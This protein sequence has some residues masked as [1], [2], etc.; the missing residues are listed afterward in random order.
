MICPLCSHPESRARSV[1]AAIAPLVLAVALFALVADASDWYVAA[2]RHQPLFVESAR[3]PEGV[4]RWRYDDAG[5]L[6]P[7][8]RMV[9]ESAMQEWAA[10]CGIRFEQS[11]A[12]DAAPFAWSDALPAHVGAVTGAN[13]DAAGLRDV[14]VLFNAPALRDLETLYHVARHEIGHAIGLAHSDVPD[15]VMSGPPFTP[16]AIFTPR[17]APD[18]VAGCVALYG[19]A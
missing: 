10:A 17:L 6:H 7:W 19:P 18:D 2:P 1:R 11:D 3:L 12:S 13:V 8:A 16:Y 15:A 5:E 4:L 14:L 9:I